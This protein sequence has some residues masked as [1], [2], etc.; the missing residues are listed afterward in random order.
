MFDW[1]GEQLAMYCGPDLGDLIIITLNKYVRLISSSLD[2]ADASF[3]APLKLPLQSFFFFDASMYSMPTVASACNRLK[4]TQIGSSSSSQQSPVSTLC[5]GYVTSAHTHNQSIIGV[6]LLHLLL[7]PGTAFL[8]GGVRI[9]E[10]QLHPHRSQLN[11]TL[12]TVGSV[13]PPWLCLCMQSSN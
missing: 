8:T 12:L 13:P 6:V 2:H 11:L 3:P 1:G 7:I 5:P 4:L 9:W 10:Q